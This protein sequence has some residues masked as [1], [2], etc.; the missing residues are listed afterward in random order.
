MTR[1]VTEFEARAIRIDGALS[2]RNL[3][4][5]RIKGT[6]ANTDTAFDIGATGGTF[7]AEADGTATGLAALNALKSI[8]TKVKALLS[9]DGKGI[10]DRQKIDAT[11]PSITKLDSAASAGGNATETM[12]VTGL[13]TTDTILS[14][15]Q[16]VDGAGAAVGILAFGGATGVCSVNDQLST[17]WN[18]D[19]GAG[20]KIRVAVQ[21][22]STTVNAG[23]YKAVQNTT[24]F[25]PDLTF[26]SGD[27]PTAFEFI[28]ILLLKDGELPAEYEVAA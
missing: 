21:R 22:D 1:A 23:Q 11:Y 20:A 2:G 13:L 24:S 3:Q 25:I 19:P 8:Q 18:A 12:T 26:A 10:T 27:A 9:F 15:C 17:T 6:A 28:A 14:V 7:W 5:V 16:F 4:M